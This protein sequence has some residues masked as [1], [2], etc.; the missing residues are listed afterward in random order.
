MSMGEPVF[1]TEWAK[2]YHGIGVNDDAMD[3]RLH[4][5]PA[6]VGGSCAWCG[7]PLP[8]AR[9]VRCTNDGSSQRS[10]QFDTQVCMNAHI[11]CYD[12]RE[13]EE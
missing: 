3:L 12:S 4:G 8:D 13:E 6:T 10:W 7:L 9:W 1:E 5:I 11:D 2:V